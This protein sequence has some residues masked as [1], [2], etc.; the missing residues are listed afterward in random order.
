[1]MLAVV[2]ATI[3][4][5][6][7]RISIVTAFH[8]PRSQT[9][10]KPTLLFSSTVNI[11]DDD[12]T[13]DNSI[14]AASILEGTSPKAIKLRQ[15]VQSILNNPSKTFPVIIHGPS[16]EGS[17]TEIAED[18]ISRLPSWQ[19]QQVYRISLDDSGLDY[20]DTILGSTSHPGILDDIAKEQNATLLIKGFNSQHVDSKAEFDRRL[21]LVNGLA[22]LVSQ[23]EFIS[24]Y[25]NNETIQFLPRI[26]GCTQRK[27]YLQQ[28]FGVENE[29]EIDA[30][31]INV[32]TVQSRTKDLKDIAKAKIRKL[33]SSLGLEDVTLSKEGKRDMHIL[34]CI[35]FILF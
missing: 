10:L 7:G 16:G 22:R 28:Y 33:E 17:K 30:M 29:K 4:L 9:N 12:E 20:I 1:M 3:L 19:T 31:F 34:A 13:Y 23:R 24:R 32:P 14:V 5:P 18:I 15:Q 8:V 27:D 26:I 25:N 6:V 2:V 11:N 35:M 21:E